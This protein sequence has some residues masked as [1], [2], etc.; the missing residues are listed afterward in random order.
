M[1]GLKSQLN[2]DSLQAHGTAWA[3]WVCGDINHT[4][5]GKV[6]IL[7]NITPLTWLCVRLGNR[8]P[9]LLLLLP[10]P[11]RRRR[12]A[13]GWG[14]TLFRAEARTNF[15]PISEELMRSLAKINPLSQLSLYVEQMETNSI[16]C[17]TQDCLVDASKPGPPTINWGVP[18]ACGRAL[19]VIGLAWNIGGGGATVALCKNISFLRRSR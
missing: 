6:K 19:V 16:F 14:R 3:L 15:I 8:C 13:Q 11:R 5:K 12:R 7:S 10:R 9:V 4:N 17:P 1:H 2:T 18:C